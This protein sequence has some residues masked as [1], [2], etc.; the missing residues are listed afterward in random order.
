VAFYT[1]R[2]ITKVDR[3]FSEVVPEIKCPW[4]KTRLGVTA[5][6]N[7][8]SALAALMQTHALLES[9]AQRLQDCHG[10]KDRQGNTTKCVSPLLSPPLCYRIGNLRKDK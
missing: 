7:F 10:R 4:D 5:K 3:T 8:W 1:S 6:K 9:N 2:K